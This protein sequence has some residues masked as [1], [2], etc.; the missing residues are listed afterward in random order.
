MKALPA[1][2]DANLIQSLHNLFI[3]GITICETI[4]R[5]RNPSLMTSLVSAP[6]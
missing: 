4:S 6:V 2:N 1:K 3:F 5:L